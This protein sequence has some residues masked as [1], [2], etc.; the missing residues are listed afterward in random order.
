[1]HRTTR[2]C[3]FLCIIIERVTV[4][5]NTHANTFRGHADGHESSLICIIY[6]PYIYIYTPPEPEYI[7]YISV[8]FARALFTSYDD[9]YD[10]N[11]SY[12]IITWALTRRVRKSLLV[13]TMRSS[14]ADGIV[15][16]FMYYYCIHHNIRS[17]L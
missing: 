17:L 2:R 3:A 5:Y 7:I 8:E 14:A 13:L 6:L 10:N 12:L 15:V 9:R 16:I 4:N 1:M 11:I